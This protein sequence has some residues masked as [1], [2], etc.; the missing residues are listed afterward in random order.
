MNLKKKTPQETHNSPPDHDNENHEFNIL[1]KKNTNVKIIQN[2]N[3]N[4]KNANF[5]FKVFKLLNT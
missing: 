3:N 5:F 2:K 4:N 1:Q